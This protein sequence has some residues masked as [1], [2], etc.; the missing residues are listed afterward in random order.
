MVF[1]QLTE[2]PEEYWNEPDYQALVAS[3]VR[4]PSEVVPSFY[5]L[6]INTD[7]DTLSFTGDVYITIRASRKVKEIILHSK[8]LSIGP[9][10]KLTEQIFEKVETVQ[11]RAKRDVEQTSIPPTGESNNEA[12]NASTPPPP[13]ISTEKA[14]DNANTTEAIMNDTTIP[15]TQN[16][17]NASVHS[18]NTSIVTDS[19][20][21]ITD[22]Q[23]NADNITSRRANFETQVTTSSVRNIKIISILDASGD[24]L[25]LTLASALKPNVDYTLEMSFQGNISNSMT[26]FYKSTYKNEKQEERYLQFHNIILM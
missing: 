8:Y 22:S 2:K 11:R 13:S 25:I 3:G 16:D 5:R 26:G 15:S 10:P 23:E 20:A 1:F 9:N 17:F 4:L 12:Q 24:R 19:L 21:N 6:K 18:S 7:L 14:I